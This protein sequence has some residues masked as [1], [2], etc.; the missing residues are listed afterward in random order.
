M[1]ITEKLKSIIFHTN[2]S[3]QL[4]VDSV[5]DWNNPLEILRNK[6][7]EVPTFRAGRRKSTDLLQLS[8]EELLSEWMASRKDITTGTQFTHR[9]WYHTLYGDSMTGKKILDVGSG[10]AIDSIT[11][12]EQGANVTFVDI[13]E[14]NLVVVERICN[15]LGLSEA[16]YVLL[17]GLTALQTLDKDYDVIMA[18]GSL[19]H[20]P[21]EI[22]KPE[23][24]TL[25]K[26]LRIGGRWIQLAYPKT[27]WIR[28]GQKPFDQWGYIT[29]G[30]G[31]P[32]AEWYDLP[33]LL[34]LLEPAIFD[35][36]LCLEFHNNDFIWFDLQYKGHN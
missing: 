25:L 4:S 16:K 26:H 29:D 2:E 28:D 20:A 34:E 27:R 22:I 11:F 31:T 32:W 21:Y 6:W 18:L 24:R 35:V 3:G 19:H 33:K 36:V 15:K 5:V 13:V 8:D 12:L 1:K 9:G 7:V 14:S 10:F 30:P 17:D 23:A